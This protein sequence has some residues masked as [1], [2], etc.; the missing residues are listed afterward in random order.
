M[1]E[2]YGTC[3]SISA[4]SNPVYFNSPVQ[5]SGQPLKDAL[6]IRDE[7]HDRVALMIASLVGF[8]VALAVNDA[9]ITA[10]N[11]YFEENDVKAKIIYAL[12][13]FVIAVIIIW[14]IVVF[15]MPS[16]ACYRWNKS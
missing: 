11:N 1:T 15:I 9:I 4:N 12:I 8:L 7:F 16:R 6:C 13:I 3:S 10:I 5:S 14:F 2:R